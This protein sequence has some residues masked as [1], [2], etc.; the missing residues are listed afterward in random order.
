MKGR[1]RLAN[2]SWESLLGAHATLMK[3]LQAARVWGELTMREYDVLYTLSKS[4]VPMRLGTLHH[5]VLLSQ[6]ALSRLVDR[7]VQ[8][9]YVKRR[10]DPADARGVLLGLTE[11]GRQAQI[12][13]GRRHARSVAAAMTSRL[14]AE[15]LGLLG[16]L[17]SKLRGST[18]G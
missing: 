7:L 10:Q 12:T 9:G 3:E 4:A 16:E 6:P 8:R 14:D 18:T 11:S 15:E 17:T 2:E 13:V 1:V 5:E